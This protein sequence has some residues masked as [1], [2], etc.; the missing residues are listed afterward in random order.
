MRVR[1][2]DVLVGVEVEDAEGRPGIDRQRVAVAKRVGHP[3]A[4]GRNGRPLDVPPAGV[5]GDGKGLLR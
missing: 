5:V 1:H 3:L 2:L 4:V